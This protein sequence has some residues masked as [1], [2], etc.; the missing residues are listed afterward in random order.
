[1][2][3][4]GHEDFGAHMKSFGANLEESLQSMSLSLSVCFK[5]SGNRKPAGFRL[6]RSPEGS[7][8]ARARRAM[9]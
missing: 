9:S 4:R 5:R 7:A 8:V 1:V 6:N 3:R 2:A